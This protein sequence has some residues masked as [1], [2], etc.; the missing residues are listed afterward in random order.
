MRDILL[1]LVEAEHKL[2]R[3]LTL[4][5]ELDQGYPAEIRALHEANARELELLIDDDGWPTTDETGPDGVDAAFRIALSSLSRPAFLRRCL[6]LMK[7]AANR[8]DIPKWHPATLEDRIRLLE[9]RG[10]LYGTQLDWDDDGHLTPYPIEDEDFVAERRKKVGLPPLAE[11][12][13]QAELAATA[14]RPVE[15]WIYRRQLWDQ[16]AMEM[17]WRD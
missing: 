9:G 7:M 11:E 13:A 2:S 12:L 5:G 1:R 14:N 3:Q 17:G 4:S 6:T 8:G 10:Q 16:F 15:E